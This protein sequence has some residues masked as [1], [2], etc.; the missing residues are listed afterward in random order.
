MAPFYKSALTD[1]ENYKDFRSV[2][3]NSEISFYWNKK[4]GHYDVS[5]YSKVFRGF[6]FDNGYHNY[7][8]QSC[9]FLLDV[10]HIYIVDFTSPIFNTKNKTVT[11]FESAEKRDK[12][13]RSNPTKMG[14]FFRKI[15]PYFNDKQIEF[16][17]NYTV[18]HLSDSIYTHHI[19]K[20]DEITQVY[21][22]KAESGKDIG[23]YA[24]INASCMKHDDW[25]IH[26]TKVYATESWELHYLTNGDGDIGARA[27]VC[28]EDNTY[29]YIYAS[30]EHAGDILKKYLEDLDFISYEHGYKP[31]EGA[32]L[33]KIEGNGGLVAPYIDGHSSVKDCDDHLEISYR[34]ADYEFTSIRGYVN[35]IVRSECACCG[36][37]CD[38]YEMIVIDGELYCECCWFFCD[39]YQDFVVGEPNFVY[40]SLQGFTVVCDDAL[41]DMGAIYNENLKE[42]QTKEWYKECTKE[43]E[44]DS[45]VEIEPEKKIVPGDSR[46]FPHCKENTSGILQ[47]VEERDLVVV[48]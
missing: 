20:G 18:E 47:Y 12:R 13:V 31:F 33:L 36:S 30:C 7:C 29:N 44:E 19:T 46:Y 5:K 8:N 14:K 27:L 26:P 45:D 25:D 34:G 38:E 16:L 32:K 17:I 41:E 37:V 4:D 24:C 40:Y 39:H 35:Y 11:F 21:L 15:A 6:E 9:D 23:G 1:C 42:W 10:C 43:D 22:S 48:K 28:K 2:I 3:G